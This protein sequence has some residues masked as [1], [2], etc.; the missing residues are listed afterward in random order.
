MRRWLLHKLAS[1]APD[2]K[3]RSEVRSNPYANAAL[4]AYLPAFCE[5]NR[6][7]TR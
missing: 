4:S 2:L 7:E 3:N 6:G 5:Q 1:P